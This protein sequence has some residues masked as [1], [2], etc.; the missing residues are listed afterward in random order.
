[1]RVV[2]PLDLAA[3]HQSL[4][5]ALDAAYVRV[6]DSGQFVG[7][8]EVALFEREVAEALGVAYAVGLSS[9]TDALL[10]ALRIAEV[11]PGDEVITTAFSFFATSETVLQLGATPVFVDCAPGSFLLDVDA[12][13]RAITPRTKAIVPVHLY[14]E[15]VSM[16]PLMELAEAYGLMVIEDAAQAIGATSIEADL[17]GRRRMAGGLGHMGVQLLA[18]TTPTKIIAV[19]TREEAL[20]LARRAGAEIAV[21]AGED[22]PAAILDATKGL[23][24]DVVI[25]MVGSDESLT[26][27]TSVARSYSHITVVGIGGGSFSFGFFSVPYECSVATTYWGS[28]PELL[29][30]IELARRGLIR[31]EV[32][33]VGLDEAAGAYEDLANGRVAG[34]LVVV[35]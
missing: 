14:G 6:R 29:E 22:A 21:D 2:P 1:M 23:G 17:H 8:D 5:E 9:G 32:T 12:V 20:T 35:P 30:V 4:R 10:L 13:A 27:A 33:R 34:R 25:D 26:L 28:L 16:A 7:G 24:A 3:E 11:G 19:D 31:A 15:V 18:A